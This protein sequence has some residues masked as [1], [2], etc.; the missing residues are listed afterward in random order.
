MDH[1]TK[2]TS[3]LPES[4]PR[5]PISVDEANK[6]CLRHVGLGK[7]G[8]RFTEVLPLWWDALR[9]ADSPEARLTCER[10]IDAINRAYGMDRHVIG[11]RIAAENIAW[12]DQDN[13]DRAAA[14]AAAADAAAVDRWRAFRRGSEG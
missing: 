5:H 11:A 13:A 8:N 14:E 7:R 6:A 9:A 3:M 2:L 1:E 10:M 4:F 12:R